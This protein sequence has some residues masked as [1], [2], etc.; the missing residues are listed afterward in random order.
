MFATA[1][2]NGGSLNDISKGVEFFSALKKAGN[3]VPV[4]A[5][6]A[7]VANGQTPITLDWHYLQGK[8]KD[9]LSGKVDWKVVIPSDAVYGGFY[10]QAIVKNSPHPAAARL[11][12]E[13]LYSDQGQNLFLKGGTEPIRLPA[14]IK[15][16]TANKTYLADLA[17][18]PAGA[19]PQFASLVQQLLA[20]VTVAQ[21]WSKI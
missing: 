14:M 15:K 18:L 7:T 2:A 11:W 9:D 6:P 8:Y 21:N 16:G 17:P 19:K 3:F 13:F 5:T 10:A 4:E 1:L 20:K 12:Q